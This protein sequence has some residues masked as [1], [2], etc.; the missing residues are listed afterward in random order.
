[1]DVSNVSEDRAA[2][3]LEPKDEGSMFHATLPDFYQLQG[4]ASHRIIPCIW[5][6][7]VIQT[8]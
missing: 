7:G 8:G 5:G 3:I 1:L 2:H 4:V 6:P